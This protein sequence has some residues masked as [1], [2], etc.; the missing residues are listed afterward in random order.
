MIVLL[1][2]VTGITWVYGL[3]VSSQKLANSTSKRIEAIQIAR[4]GLEAFTNIRDTNWILYGADYENCWNVLNYNNAC[5]WISG[6]TNDIR[7]NVNEWFKIYRNSENKF[8]LALV[9]YATWET[10][11][12]ALYRSGFEIRKESANLFYTQSWGIVYWVWSDPF[13]TREIQVDYLDNSWM[14]L[15]GLLSDN[16]RMRVTAVV[17]WNDIA[18]QEPQKLEMSTILTNW[19]A[20]K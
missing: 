7:H 2:V 9:S 11:A 13:Y 3:L 20:K 6:V 1:V 15:W 17:Q 19:K 8:R 12:D 14:S 10:Y 18:K 16:D 5:I 4:D